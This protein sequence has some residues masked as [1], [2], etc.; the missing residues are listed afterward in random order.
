VPGS[1]Q[2]PPSGAPVLFLADAPTTGGYPVV[3]VLVDADLDR[4][5]QL[6]PG[7]LLGFRPVAA[8]VH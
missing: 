5:G 2:V 7:Q 8:P 1:L 6:R 3:A 4:A